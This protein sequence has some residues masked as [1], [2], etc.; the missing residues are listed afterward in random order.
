MNFERG[1]HRLSMVFWGFWGLIAAV[2]VLGGLFGNASDGMSLAGGGAAGM[3]AAYIAHRL[4]C[5][6][7]SGFFAPRA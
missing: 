6:V 7:V 3:V 1:I 5:W 4:T 2:M